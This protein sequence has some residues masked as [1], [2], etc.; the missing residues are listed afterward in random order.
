MAKNLRARLSPTD[1]LVIHDRNTE[2]TSNFMQEVGIAASSVG[3]EEKGVNM[4]VASSVREVA[5]KSVCAPTVSF[6]MCS[7][8]QACNDELDFPILSDLSWVLP[9]AIPFLI[10]SHQSQS[11]EHDQSFPLFDRNSHNNL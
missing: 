1:H 6:T 10:T 5:E 3:A 2:A 9:W 7:T 4:E 11:S 8:H